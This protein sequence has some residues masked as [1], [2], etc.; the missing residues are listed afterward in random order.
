MK[1][2]LRGHWSRGKVTLETK[3]LS[4]VVAVEIEGGERG[5]GEWVVNFEYVKCKLVGKTMHWFGWGEWK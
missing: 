5:R 3:W 4:V 1:V 2:V